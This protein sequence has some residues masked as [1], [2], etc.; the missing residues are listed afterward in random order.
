MLITVSMGISY[1]T[2]SLEV[3]GD[4]AQNNLDIALVRGG[5]QVVSA[6]TRICSSKSKLFSIIF[7]KSS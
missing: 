3:I 6:E 5:D 2:E 1:G 4:E 7:S